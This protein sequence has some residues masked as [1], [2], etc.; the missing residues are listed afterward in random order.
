MDNKKYTRH[1]RAGCYSTNGRQLLEPIGADPKGLSGYHGS[2]EH[3]KGANEMKTKPF[4]YYTVILKGM[5]EHEW[6]QAEL[7]RVSGISEGTISNIL[8]GRTKTP[9]F[10]TIEALVNA[11]GLNLVALGS[12]GRLNNG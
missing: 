8:S 4:D 5:A 10:E 1:N 7:A 3:S 9:A 6:T 2:P 11:L 12:A